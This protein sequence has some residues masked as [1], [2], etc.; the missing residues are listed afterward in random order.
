[1]IKINF[2]STSIQTEFC[3]FWWKNTYFVKGKYYFFLMALEY[4]KQSCKKNKKKNKTL[5]FYVTMNV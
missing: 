3:T 1:M 5:I 4:I 2:P